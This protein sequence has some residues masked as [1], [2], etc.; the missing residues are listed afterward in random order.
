MS[1]WVYLGMCIQPVAL[2]CCTFPQRGATSGYSQDWT[3]DRKLNIGM[4]IYT[5]THIYRYICVYVGPS[6]SMW[7][8]LGFS[9]LN[10]ENSLFYSALR[11]PAMFEIAHHKAT[12]WLFLQ[13]LQ[14]VPA[15]VLVN[16]AF[17]ICQLHFTLLFS[18]NFPEANNATSY[19]KV[20]ATYTYIY[21][22]M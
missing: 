17:P 16:K 8:Y 10:S 21:I 20:P 5:H 3:Q 12:K 14:L 11:R 1:P 9:G 18:G 7:Q 2:S 13:Y 15:K 6:G 22:Y 4:Y 19:L